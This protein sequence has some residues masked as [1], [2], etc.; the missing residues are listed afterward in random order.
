ME[1]NLF[2]FNSKIKKEVLKLLKTGL[3]MF[4]L[5]IGVD[6]GFGVIMDDLYFKQGRSY[7]YG[8]EEAKEDIL[9]LGSSRA[10]HHYVPS[11]MEDSLQLTCFNFGSG[12]QNI[13]YHYAILKSALMRYKP[14]LI[15]L[16]LGDIDFYNTPG[17]N[18]EK[19]SIINPAYFKYVET[20][21]VIDLKGKTEKV[22]L[23]SSFYR[24]NG[25]VIRTI[26]YALFH[27]NTYFKKDNKGYFPLQGEWKEELA[28]EE[29]E[30][31]DIDIQKID[32]LRRCI[33]LCKDKRVK[34][35][36]CISPSFVD[37]EEDNRLL[38]HNIAN[39]YNISFFNYEQ[40]SYFLNH[41]K[42]FRDPGHLNYKGAEI[43]TK[44]I[45]ADI[46]KI[47]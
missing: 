21:E 47:K 28:L 39:E 46:N 40:N 6:L 31:Q 27:G 34:I 8:I 29:K 41:N 38:L 18:T 13:Y 33:E 11:I 20:D 22:K 44:M 17:W 4:A 30:S 36:M 26:N 1:G 23:F 3:I 45:I 25:E 2:I 43:Y 24:Y 12:G 32:Y 35:I 10:M 37:K 42:L 7:L 9:I 15:I 5:L 19:L 14:K 16:E